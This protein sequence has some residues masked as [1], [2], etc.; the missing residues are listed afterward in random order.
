MPSWA[1][2]SGTWSAASAA[3]V[4]DRTYIIDVYQAGVKAQGGDATSGQTT[5]DYL[6]GIYGLKTDIFE[7]TIPAGHPIA[8]KTFD[9]LCKEYHVYII[10]S[11]YHGKTWFAPVIQTSSVL[12]K[13]KRVSLDFP[14]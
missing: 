1:Q 7:I 11:A 5:K 4:P 13:P 6:K 3:G 9:D 10:G 14:S 2:S 12:R 8:G